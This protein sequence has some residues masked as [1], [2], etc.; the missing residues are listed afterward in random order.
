MNIKHTFILLVLTT[1]TY[2]QESALF[3]R[4]FHYRT[5]DNKSKNKREYIVK[6][7]LIE[8][9]DF[10]NNRLYRTAE[11]YG[12]KDLKNLDEFIWYNSNRQYDKSP[13]LKLTN[14]KGIVK[15]LNKDGKTTSELLYIEDKTKFIQLWN[16][17]KSYLINGTGKFERNYVKNNEKQVRIFKD[18]IETEG[19]IVRE[20]KKDTI[21]YITDTKSYPKTGLKRFYK[22][23]ASRI[24]YPKFSK[25]IG[26][27]KKIK[28]EFV[29]DENGNLT[30][31]VPI[32]KKSL[33]FEK[34]AI[35][36]L[37][38]MPKWI[39]A[40]INGKRVKTRFRIPLTFKH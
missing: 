11:F 33:N 5:D 16:K 12:F 30:D 34:K 7:S 38:K 19:Y 31:F 32:N 10:K 35:K 18:S 2:G 25:Y 36:Q 4:S 6:D 40:T 21:Y 37:K 9:K 20:L 22:D 28:I 17:D 39:P 24:N 15:Y 29:V 8:I 27:D 1:F 14:R 13:D 26:M 23:L 3:D